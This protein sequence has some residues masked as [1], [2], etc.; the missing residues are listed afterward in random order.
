MSEQTSPNILV[1][2]DL[3][4]ASKLKGEVQA[5]GYEYKAAIGIKSALQR[6]K[7]YGPSAIVIELSKENLDFESLITNLRED[8]A[9]QAIPLIG[10]CGHMDTQKLQRAKELGC[11][12]TC[13]NGQISGDFKGVLGTAL[14]N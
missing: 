3:F 7:D 14:S 6:A 13:S 10:F 5:A 4:F 2:A 12:A 11:K 8:E 9:T 1:V